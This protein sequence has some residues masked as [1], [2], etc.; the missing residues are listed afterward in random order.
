MRCV[1]EFDAARERDA[2]E[3]RCG[4][5]AEECFGGNPRCEG[6][7]EFL[8]IEL[9]RRWNMNTVKWMLKITSSQPTAMD[10]EVARGVR[11]EWR[12]VERLGQ[13]NAWRGH[14]QRI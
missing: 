7:A 12:G 10:T 5:S 3:L 9:D 11:S 4:R 14:A 2:V 1:L 6:R 13:R 8:D